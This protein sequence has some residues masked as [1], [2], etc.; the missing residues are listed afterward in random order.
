MNSL[1]SRLST[2][3][4]LYV[5]LIWALFGLLIV[6]VN[7]H[8]SAWARLAMVVCPASGVIANRGLLRRSRLICLILVSA[9]EIAMFTDSLSKHY[10]TSRAHLMLWIALGWVAGML[11]LAWRVGESESQ[12]GR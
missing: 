4:K 8:E 11:L 10:V 7:L 1:F 9:V 12:E 5:C 3:R 6:G 2:A